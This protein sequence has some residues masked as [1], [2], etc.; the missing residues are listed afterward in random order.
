MKSECE[1]MGRFAELLGDV[2]M[3]NPLEDSFSRLTH[4]QG[5]EG[6]FHKLPAALNL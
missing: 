1:R 6:F 2:L 3:K 4:T 5:L